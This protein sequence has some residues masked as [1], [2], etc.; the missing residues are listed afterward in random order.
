MV[1][2]E[3]IEIKKDEMIIISPP[4]SIFLTVYTCFPFLSAW[5]RCHTLVVPGVLVSK[6]ATIS[7]VGLYFSATNFC[8]TLPRRKCKVLSMCC[9]RRFIGCCRPALQLCCCQWKLLGQLCFSKLHQKIIYEATLPRCRQNLGSK[10]Q[11]YR[12]KLLQRSVFK[13][14]SYLLHHPSWKHTYWYISNL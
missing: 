13:N 3:N 8:S 14:T 2:C 1:T 12:W 4:W 5:Q 9:F 10:T 6:S 11:L 7:G